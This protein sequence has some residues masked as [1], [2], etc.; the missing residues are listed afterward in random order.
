MLH[1]H[2]RKQ[3]GDE[4]ARPMTPDKKDSDMEGWQIMLKQRICGVIK[5]DLLQTAMYIIKQLFQ[6]KQKEGI[7]EQS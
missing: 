1:I 6:H 7:N 4:K 5:L 3:G 2:N